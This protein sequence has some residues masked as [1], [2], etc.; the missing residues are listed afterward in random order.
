MALQPLKSSTA[1]WCFMVLLF[2][3]IIFPAIVFAIPNC[4]PSRVVAA[5]MDAVLDLGYMITS[6]W[7]YI[8]F[9]T[10]E[11]LNSIFL[12]NIWDYMSLYICVAHVLCIC[13]SLESADW[14][15]LFQVQHTKPMWSL[16][17]RILFSSAYACAL[18]ASVGVMLGR[19]FF[20]CT[21]CWTLPTMQLLHHRAKI[22][23]A[24][25]LSAS[26]RLFCPCAPTLVV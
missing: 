7:L 15:A 1:V 14:V 2:S 23:S 17:K 9:A 20:A 8:G 19:C 21:K 13:R 25:A 4:V 5:A 11:A 16:L 24:G 10:Q 3:N 12:G 6:L 22:P 18:A 26:Q